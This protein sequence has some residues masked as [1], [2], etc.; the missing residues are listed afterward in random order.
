MAGHALPLPSEAE[1]LEESGEG[2]RAWSRI[3]CGSD[4]PCGSVAHREGTKRPSGTCRLQPISRSFSGQSQDTM[5]KVFRH[6]HT[7]L[8]QLIYMRCYLWNYAP[9]LGFK[10]HTKR[11]PHLQPS[12][13]GYPAGQEIIQQNNLLPVFEGQGQHGQFSRTQVQGQP[14]FRHMT[15]IHA[16]DPWALFNHRH[17]V[18]PLPSGFNLYYHGI[19]NPYF[20]KKSC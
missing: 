20:G 14:L 5:P 10:K 6:P 16:F 15:R 3:G 1:E 12:G 7:C 4:I 18:S 8:D 17:V 19:R 2:K 9:F 13:L 11:S